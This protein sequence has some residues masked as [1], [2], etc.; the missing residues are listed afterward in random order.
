MR[1]VIVRGNG[2]GELP[3][4]A[5]VCHDVRNP[6]QRNE[7][8]VR[9]GSLVSDSQIAALLSRGIG[10][11]HLAVAACDDVGEDEAAQQLA[12]AAAGDNVACAA[13]HFGQVSFTSSARGLLRVDANRLDRINTLEGVLVLTGEADRPVEV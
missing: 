5:A 4:T 7:V 3:E 2:A 13:A 1:M 8:L 6:E 10:E 11:L 12:R 9:K